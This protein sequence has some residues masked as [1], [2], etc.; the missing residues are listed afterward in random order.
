M[1]MR[2]KNIMR[3]IILAANYLKVSISFNKKMIKKI[4]RIVTI[5]RMKKD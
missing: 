3:N 2:I 4:I 1:N 5:K